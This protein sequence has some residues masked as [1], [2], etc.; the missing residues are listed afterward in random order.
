MVG[1]SP[2]GLYET[3]AIALYE[4][5]GAAAIEEMLK[6]SWNDLLTDG[7]VHVENGVVCTNAIQGNYGNFE[8]SSNEVLEGDL[9]LPNHNVIG[10]NAF[11]DC[12]NLTGILIPS[13]VTSVD[14]YAFHACEMLETVVFDNSQLN[15]IGESA[16]QYCFELTAIHIPDSVISIGESAFEYCENITSISIGKNVIDIGLNAFT[17]CGILENIYFN[18]KSLNENSKY[19]NDPIFEMSGSYSDAV[20]III[21]KDVERIPSYLFADI[22]NVTSIEFEENSSC[23][24]IGS[25]AFYDIRPMAV[26]TII[27]HGT[28]NEWKSIEQNKFAYDSDIDT[29]QCSD[30][31]VEV[32]NN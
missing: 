23:K 14:D 21:G 7:V 4:S 29:I 8:N 5:E 9:I 31:I 27:Y 3:G 18:S 16:F 10:Q 11:A 2:P 17:D 25:Y 32:R 19:Y 15:S 13:S 12:H 6:I 22:D 24:Y 26:N 28:C 1:S 20:S 30:G